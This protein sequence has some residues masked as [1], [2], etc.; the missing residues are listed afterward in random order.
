MQA[1]PPRAERTSIALQARVRRR[2]VSH[3]PSPCS[4]SR[5]DHAPIATT[6]HAATQTTEPTAPT[7][8]ASESSQPETAMAR[9]WPIRMV[10]AGGCRKLDTAR[11]MGRSPQSMEL[12]EC[13]GRGDP[14]EIQ[15]FATSNGV[16]SLPFWLCC[17]CLCL[18]GIVAFLALLPF[19]LPPPPA[20]CSAR[21]AGVALSI[22]HL[23][24]APKHKWRHGNAGRTGS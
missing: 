9:F 10:L 23:Y 5:S 18:F 2:P 16:T 4:R 15:I 6:R 11:A 3:Q 22:S 1:R 19:G 8:S 13:A 21:P 14:K 7:P 12:V 17:L 20:A 24:P